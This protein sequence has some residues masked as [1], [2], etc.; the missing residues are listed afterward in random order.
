[1]QDT[2]YSSGAAPFRRKTD[3]SVNDEN[4][5]IKIMTLEADL[6]LASQARDDLSNEVRVVLSC[7]PVQLGLLFACSTH[8]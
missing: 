7:Y 1:M 3:D 2:G 4:A 5:R 8:D 6:R